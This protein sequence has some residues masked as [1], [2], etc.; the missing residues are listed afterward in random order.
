[1]ETNSP[2]HLARRVLI[3]R[4][5]ALAIGQPDTPSGFE[6]RLAAENGWSEA[7]AGR[8]VVEYRR[9]LA[10]VATGDEPLTPSDAVDQAWHLHMVHSRDYWHGLC[11]DIVGRDIHHTPGGDGAD[12]REDYRNRYAR[13]IDLYRATFGDAPPADIWP[14]PAARFVGR[15]RRV[16]LTTTTLF[17]GA[18]AGATAGGAGVMAMMALAGMDHVVTLLLIVVAIAA[19]WRYLGRFSRSGG[20]AAGSD[21]FDWDFGLSDGGSG[22]CGGDGGCGGGGCGGGCS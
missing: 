15:F 21:G 17:G 12:E 3:G 8:V 2:A 9:F 16:D 1:M 18:A 11:R 4:I 14:D 13:T 20:R 6:R 19:L 22:G 7:F 5:E 10:L